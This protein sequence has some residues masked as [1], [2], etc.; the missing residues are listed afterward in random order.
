LIAAS[1]LVVRPIEFRRPRAA[2]APLADKSWSVLLDGDDNPQARFAYIAADPFDV[3]RIETATAD[4]FAGLSKKLAE[5]K[6]TRDG[7]PLPV[8]FIGGA[9]GFVGYEVAHALE[10]LPPRK[11]KAWPWDLAF[12]FYDA[13]AVFDL[14]LRRAWIIS[15]GF[16]ETDETRRKARA[17]ERAAALEHGLGVALADVPPPPGGSWTADLGE[18]SYRSKARR[19]IDYIRAGDIFQANLTQ[20]WT[21]PWP[22]NAAAFDLYRRLIS[23][24]AAPFA[25]YLSLGETTQIISASP[26]RFLSVDH[27]GRVETRPI[28]GTRPRG[29]TKEEDFALAA[30]LRAS[31]KDRAENLMIVDLL[32]ND[33]SR[34]CRAGSVDVPTLCGLESFPTVHHLV[35][36]VTGQLRPECSAVD[37][38]AACFP[39]GSITG[40]PKIRAMQIIHELEPVA[41]GPYCGTVAWFG[42]DGAM[43]SSIVIRTLTRD[44][45]TLTAQAGG[46]VVADSVPAQEYAESVLKARPLLAALTGDHRFACAS[47]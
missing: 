22:A 41:R 18:A 29:A 19:I 34:V 14:K 15:S 26:E 37:L 8:P 23:L 33:L 16:P 38:L 21:A 32:R 13:V 5:Y 27:S 7:T 1:A 17:M 46:G 25:A 4:P 3:L 6:I 20:R 28:K 9:L 11:L 12:G 40:A 10:R 35:S 47:A 30:E 42:F 45:T 39:G 31:P 44:G 24:S 2:F 43:D 36:V